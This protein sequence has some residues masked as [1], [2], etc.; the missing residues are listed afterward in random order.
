MQTAK[1]KWVFWIAFE[2]RDWFNNIWYTRGS[3]YLDIQF[4]K[5]RIS[6]GMPWLKAAYLSKVRDYGQTGAMTEI[7]KA[8]AGNLNLWFSFLIG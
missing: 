6:I 1:I 4:F 8:N 7:N 2:K 5:I 3:N